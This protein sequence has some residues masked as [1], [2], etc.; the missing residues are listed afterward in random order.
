M[1]GKSSFP[2]SSSTLAL[3][4]GRLKVSWRAE[5]WKPH[6]DVVPYHTPCELNYH[7]LIWLTLIS[8][9]SIK[10][11]LVLVELVWLHINA[12]QRNYT[13]KSLTWLVC[14][15]ILSPL[16][17]CPIMFP[18]PP[19]RC[20]PWVCKF[21]ISLFCDNLVFF[22][23]C[24]WWEITDVNHNWKSPSSALEAAAL[25]RWRLWEWGGQMGW[26]L[27]HQFVGWH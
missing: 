11:G 4:F 22:K 1:I 20:L 9:G 14:C 15:H 26:E 21:S 12:I 5:T 27:W 10:S 6:W 16:C 8:M 24:A 13:K 18:P 19:P 7:F 25:L 3:L 23:G 17:L 2:W